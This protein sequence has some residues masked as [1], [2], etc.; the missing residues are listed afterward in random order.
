ML[1]NDASVSG[2][3]LGIV[4]GDM[5]RSV[6]NMD[7][8][9]QG[10]VVLFT[11]FAFLLPAFAA[12]HM[13]RQW[14]SVL[15]GILT[16]VCL[17]Y[18]YCTAG[19]AQQLGTEHAKCSPMVTHLL[20]HVFF[21]W[22]YFSLLQMAFL[23]LGP[24]D[25]RMQRVGSQSTPGNPTCS[26]SSQTPFD[27]VV[28]ARIV[29]LVTLCM[30]HM[31]HPSWNAEEIQWSNVL[32]T[33]L[34]ALLCCSVF[35]LHR[36]RR[37]RAADVLLR[38]NFWHRV[39][40][41]GFIPAMMLFWIFCIIGFANVDALHTMWHICVAFLA[42]HL[43]RLVLSTESSSVKVND[44]SPSNPNIAHVLL[45]SIALIAV[46]TSIIGASFSWCP[47]H[48]SSWVTISS[49]TDCSQGSYFV[50]IVAVP[51]FASV[52]AVF[53]LIDSTAS[54]K[55]PWQLSKS[56]QLKEVGDWPGWHESVYNPHQLAMGIRLGC[57]LGQTGAFFGLLATLIMRGGAIHDVIHLFCAVTSLGLIMIAMTLTVLSTDS[58]SSKG[59]RSR[60]KSFRHFF[61]LCVCLPVI[62]VHVMLVM[63]RQYVPSFYQNSRAAYAM[64]EYTLCIL[65]AVWPLTWAA[66][67]QDTWHRNGNGNFVWPN[68]QNRFV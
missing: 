4:Q 55:A 2:D 5:E 23:I 11:S 24:E 13:Q 60:Y 22:I 37:F 27:V 28:T 1:P 21:L 46:P 66:E 20:T 53:G 56:S 42:T 17:P 50:A 49:A 16:L 62:V 18:H 31:A 12:W 51:T 68:T 44:V 63:A 9:S 54:H 64:I 61:T 36:S 41:T 26:M 30:F 14:H 59:T 67:V 19:G 29:P 38:Y 47:D 10:A 65:L 3:F 8:N 57:M 39:L 35:W 48:Q 34:L 6:D 52:A 7:L 33:E 58:A 15:F 25:P 45:S 32:L 40:H 43:L